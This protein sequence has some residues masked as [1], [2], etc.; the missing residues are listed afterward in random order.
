MV[1]IIGV[2]PK[3]ADEI[4]ECFKGAHQTISTEPDLMDVDF[5]INEGLRFRFNQNTE[6][7][8]INNDYNAV[9]LFIDEFHY[10]NII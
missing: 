4:C 10:F 9:E 5:G 6:S 7:L 2:I 3:K 1:K 8:L